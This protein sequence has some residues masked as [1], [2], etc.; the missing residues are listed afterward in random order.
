MRRRTF[1]TLMASA[2]TAAWVSRQ[3]AGAVAPTEPPA[4]AQAAERAE[5]WDPAPLP[6]ITAQP[7]FLTGVVLEWRYLAG[8]VTTLNADQTIREDFGFVCSIVDYRAVPGAQ[9]ARQEL[10]VMRED[11]LARTHSTTTY[12]GTLS[13]NSATAA[14]TFA[15]AGNPAV[16]LSW[17]LITASPQRYSFSVSS[18][19]LTLSDLTLT[20]V[21]DLIAEGGDGDISSGSLGSSSVRSDY[22]A[23]W[24]AIEQAG[25][26]VGYAR[27]DMQ[28]IRPETIGTGIGGFSHHWFAIAGNQNRVTPVWISAWQIISGNTTVWGATIAR[29]TGGGWAVESYTEESPGLAHPLAVAIVDWQAQPGT[30]PGL[31]TGQ[32]WRL[33]LGRSQPGDLLDLTVAVPAGQFITGTRVGSRSTTPMQEAVGTEAVGFV[34]GL[35]I[36][37]VQFVAAESTYSEVGAAGTATP[38]PSRTATGTATSTTTSTAT[39]TPTATTTTTH[40]ATITGTRTA[41]STATASPTRAAT[42]TGT[43]TPRPGL[44]PELYLPNLEK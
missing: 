11:F 40:T 39:H 36:T 37:P 29:N 44:E 21:G 19:E 10:I 28:T 38:T 20:P 16:Q 17:R 2:A 41:T 8:R 33:T 1:L 25:S 7:P 15:V 32:R 35:P 42:A 26:P 18:P 12:A 6:T 13:Y 3:Q 43:A 23:D 14:Y 31:R 27:L 9:D 5:W 24:V 22:Y 4:P 34:R 30:T